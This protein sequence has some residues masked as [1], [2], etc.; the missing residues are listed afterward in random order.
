M[1]PWHKARVCLVGLAVTLAFVGAIGRLYL[2]QCRQHERFA[3][4]AVRQHRTAYRLP[5]RRGTIYDRRGRH[6]A[7]SLQVESVY[8]EPHRIEDPPVVA[9]KLSSL[10]GV[11]H[12]RAH[13]RLKQQ[14]K[15]FV[16]IRRHVSS[17]EAE[18]V[19]NLG[20]IGIGLRKEWKRFYPKNGLACQ[21]IGFTNIDDTAG[22]E[23]VELSLNT[24]LAG[25]P[26]R[27]VRFR[28]A[29][30]KAIAAPG[31]EYEAPA[32]G[33]AI[34]LTI[35]A[36]AQFI[37]E[38]E[39][40]YCCE[41]WGPKSALAI[42][43]VP[44]TGDVLAL[45]SMPS[46]DPGRLSEYSAKEL[47]EACRIRAITDVMELGSVVKPLGV[48]AALQEGVVTPDTVFD[49]EHGA[50]RVGK[51]VIHDCHRYGRL[52]VAKIIEK[53]SN[54]GCS[55]I[56]FRLGKAKLHEYL[57]N[58]GLTSKSGIRLRGEVAGFMPRPEQW[59]RCTLAN[60]SF[61]QGLACNSLSLAMAYAAIANGGVLMQPRLIKEAID[62]STGERR[63]FPPKAVRR[64]L[65]ERVARELVT[66]MLVQVVASGTGKK[67]AV[68]GRVVAG[69]T[70]TGQKLDPD[71]SYSHTKF[72]SSFICYA[73][74][75]D[76]KIC[77]FVLLDEP[78]KGGSHYGGTVAAPTASRIVQRILSCP[79]LPAALEEPVVT[80]KL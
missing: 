56:A 24:Q 71:G 64:V 21:V 16:W 31:L 40:R 60:I 54:I 50:F 62:A 19:R 53:S 32:H 79:G 45:A 29:S 15:R 7:V 74:A 22:L 14:E 4:L 41:K 26:G 67:A 49:C 27:A 43:V 70:G 30:G 52:T 80:A 13:S 20:L 35:D 57:V 66:P 12:C 9:K 46:Y 39:L 47:Q 59:R 61:G 58:F 8:A 11:S 78:T 55:K 72:C 25:R 17:A 37:V 36:V 2:L 68:P 34:V 75:E 77:V 73:D 3:E 38:E 5:A 63:R 18:S 48:A 69:K 42:V 28:D 1:G 76:P 10:L 44:D 65:D 51:W 23:G 33:N 6:L